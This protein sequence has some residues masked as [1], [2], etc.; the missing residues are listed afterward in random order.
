MK[1]FGVCLAFKLNAA[2]KVHFYPFT[3]IIIYTPQM[4]QKRNF[5]LRIDVPNQYSKFLQTNKNRKKVTI[6]L[7]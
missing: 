3:Y 4:M 6:S 5:K 7:I 1:P 2:E